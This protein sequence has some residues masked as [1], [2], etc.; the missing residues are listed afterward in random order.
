LNGKFV[1]WA[2]LIGIY[3]TLVFDIFSSTNSSPQTTEL[4]ARDR[5]ETLW[6][7]VRVGAIISV[8]FIAMAVTVEKK[9]DGNYLAPIIGGMAAL[10]IMWGMYEYALRSGG[11]SKPGKRVGY[12]DW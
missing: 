2:A 3:A 9:Q 5:G 6:K 12:V 1:G 7:W 4:F 10:A 8:A 11:G